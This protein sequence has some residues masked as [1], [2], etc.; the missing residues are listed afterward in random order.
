M[1]TVAGG[2]ALVILAATGCERSAERV[3]GASP[4]PPAPQA[5]AEVE[6]QTAR[7]QRGP[8]A[9]VVSAPGS[10]LARRESQIGTEVAGPIQQVFVSEG[11]RVEAG[12]PLF[13]I[14]PVPY[15]MA[16]RAA[17][18]GYDVAVAER[19]QL[20]SDLQRAQTLR[21]QEVVSAQDLDRL[22]TQLAVAE[23]RERQADEAV[24]LARTNLERTTVR[25]PYAGSVARRLADEGTT[26]LVQPQTIVI[27]LQETGELEAHAAIP[28]SQ[29]A[30]V[31]PGDRA[32]LHVE[33][34]PA[35]IEATVSAVSDTIDAETRT[36]LVRIRVP[37]PNWTLKA[38]VFA[39]VEIHPRQRADALL[40][41]V[42][43]VRSEDGRTR[44]M[45]VRDGI[46]EAVPVEIGLGTEAV[47]E[48]VRGLAEGDEVLIG[49][50]ARTIAPGMRVRA[51]GAPAPAA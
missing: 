15:E 26:A 29:L 6:V 50:A 37:N 47:V 9:T 11:D 22:T 1:R 2:V 4:P 28:E 46:A 23:A 36:Y 24:G 44:V 10:L 3:G 51:A 35:P 19:R 45:V 25:A 32:V 31:R 27:V 49:R 48:V 17:Q 43:A 21:R 38:G 16:L 5:V 39:P 12:A 14:D 34:L 20:G 18:A 13:Q 42:E 40:V 33:G 30:L 8:V 7:V 41:P